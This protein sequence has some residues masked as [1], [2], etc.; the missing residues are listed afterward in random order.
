[1][2]TNRPLILAKDTD[3]VK[4][5]GGGTIRMDDTY[6]ENPL[7]TH[8][9]RTCSDRIHIVPIAICNTKHVEIV[10]AA[11]ASALATP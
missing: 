10:S 7:W 3:H 1:M 5:T 6:S 2:Y 8:Y 4:I 11:T 9:A